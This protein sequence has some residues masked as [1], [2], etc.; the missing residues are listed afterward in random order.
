MTCRSGHLPTSAC[1]RVSRGREPGAGTFRPRSTRDG[2]ADHAMGRVDSDRWPRSARGARECRRPRSPRSDERRSDGPR[3]T[4]APR[5]WSTAVGRPI[6][7]G[8]QTVDPFVRDLEPRVA[9]EARA[10]HHARSASRSDW[11][12][13]ASARSASSSRTTSASRR[14]RSRRAS[15][16]A[17]C[18]ARR[19][20]SDRDSSGRAKR[21]R[22]ASRSGS[23]RNV[24]I[25]IQTSYDCMT[26][27]RGG[28][29]FDEVA[30]EWALEHG[31]RAPIPCSS[32]HTT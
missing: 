16:S 4:W 21:A 8:R 28:C 15:V 29:S 13:R 12:A 1:H 17:S 10:R 3:S 24:T 32:D 25:V 14:I 23:E 6:G 5:E 20:V 19:M 27:E 22:T 26:P 2:P 7:G 31:I 18:K 30:I 11:T 9:R